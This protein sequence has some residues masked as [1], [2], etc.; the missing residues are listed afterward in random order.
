MLTHKFLKWSLPLAQTWVSKADLYSSCFRN[1]IWLHS[2]QNKS[3]QG[4]P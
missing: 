3:R 1:N 2:I 4:G